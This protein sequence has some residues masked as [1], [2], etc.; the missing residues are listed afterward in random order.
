MIDR[1]VLNGID[2]I[3]DGARPRGTDAGHLDWLGCRRHESR[4]HPYDEE[5]HPPV[6]TL[7]LLSLMRWLQQWRNRPEP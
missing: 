2:Q 1:V 5:G 4:L 6:P 7:L 3:P